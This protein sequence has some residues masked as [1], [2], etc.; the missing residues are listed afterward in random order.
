MHQT[1]RQ[2]SRSSVSDARGRRQ[3][4]AADGREGME[5]PISALAKCFVKLGKPLLDGKPQFLQ[6]DYNMRWGK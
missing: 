2:E 4:R 1:G 5:P 3:R 6:L